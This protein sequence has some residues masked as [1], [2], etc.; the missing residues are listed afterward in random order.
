MYRFPLRQLPELWFNGVKEKAALHVHILKDLFDRLEKKE[1]V[2]SPSTFPWYS[3]SISKQAIADRAC[4]IAA[5]FPGVVPREI[6]YQMI[7]AADSFISLHTIKS[8]LNVRENKQDR[9]FAVKLLANKNLCREVAKLLDST[10][11]SQ[12]N[13]LYIESLLRYKDS[14][15]RNT[16]GTIIS[17]QGD[18]EFTQSVFRLLKAKEEGCRFAALDFIMRLKEENENLAHKDVDWKQFKDAVLAIKSPST[19]EE[20]LIK[21]LFGTKGNSIEENND[22]KFPDSLDGLRLMYPNACNTSV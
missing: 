11:P 8:Y 4:I 10:T 22:E 3:V 2:F 13:I 20:P 15:I 7:E 9:D 5:R 17:E 1:K 6:A 21:N 16:A 18:E 12:E 14:N 19:R